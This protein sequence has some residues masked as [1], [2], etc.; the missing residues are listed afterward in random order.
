MFVIFYFKNDSVF[1][2][3]GFSPT[4]EGFYSKN[5]LKNFD[6]DQKYSMIVKNLLKKGDF[7]IR[8]P[9]DHTYN[10]AQTMVRKDTEEFVERLKNLYFQLIENGEYEVESDLN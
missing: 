10:P 9:F 3:C 1:V 5:D 6:F 4:G 7:L 2:F 8:E